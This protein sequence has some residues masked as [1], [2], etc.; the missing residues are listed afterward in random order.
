M[1]SVGA[2][3]GGAGHENRARMEDRGPACTARHRPALAPRGVPRVLAFPLSSPRTARLNTRSA[4]S[5]DGREQSPFG[6]LNGS[7]VSC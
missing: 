3:R 7:A 5:G 4:H 2:S 6:E 1:G